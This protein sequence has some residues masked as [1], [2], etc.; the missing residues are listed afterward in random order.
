MKIEEYRKAIGAFATTFIGTYL[1]MLAGSFS[2]TSIAFSIA[3]L[4]EPIRMSLSTG[5]FAALG[6]WGFANKIDGQNVMTVAKN[7]RNVR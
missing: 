5:L 7:P 6:A 1:M 3:E 4:I 2:D